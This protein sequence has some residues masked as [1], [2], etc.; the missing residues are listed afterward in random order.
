LDTI[1]LKALT[2]HGKH[3]FYKD[4]RIDGNT[5]EI[6][7]KASGDFKKAISKNDLEH[8]FNYEIAENIASDV[9]NGPSELL[10]ESLCY[11][12]GEL[13]FQKSPGIRKLKVSV[14]KINPPIQSKAAYAEISMKWKR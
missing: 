11:R 5:F 2:L 6:D 1:K 4:E 13:I 12:I 8:T 3:G 14:R 9:I 7:V 10:I